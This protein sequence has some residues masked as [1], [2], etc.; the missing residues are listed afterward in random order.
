MQ[1]KRVDFVRFLAIIISFL[2]LWFVCGCSTKNLTQTEKVGSI[3]VESTISGAN[4]TLDNAATG[5]LTPD[6]LFDI[7]VGSH[8]IKVE[9]EG[10]IPSPTSIMVE[11][12]A[13]TIVQAS[14]VLLDL[15][16]GSL[17]VNSNVEGAYIAID[18]T[19]TDK[20][21]PFLFDH[22]LAVGT[23]IVSLFKDG[24]SNDAPAKEVVNI[25]TTDTV[26]LT[27]NLTSDSVGKK[28]GNITPD[29]NLE[30]DFGEWYRFYAYRGFVGIVNFWALSCRYCMEELP[31][32]QLLYTEYSS[33]SLK[34]FGINYEDDFD[35]IQQKRNE[36]RLTFI[37]LKG[38]DTTVK[39]DF[40]VTGTPVT[41]I[42]DRSG[43]IYYY[44]LGFSDKPDEIQN[45]MNTFR[46]KLNEVFGK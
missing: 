42:I 24:Y 2:V 36:L 7:K 8:L 23:H 20:Q 13:D 40:E 46:Q 39:S 34:I 12:K 29:F 28:V 37:L 41:I 21:T 38:S 16:Y 32:L 44:R 10:Y 27:F 15:N 11:V 18:N 31:Y 45:I 3:F 5:K 25:T 33:D 22:N 9:K 26:R 1:N 19:P 17:G 30:D 6:T 35:I 14:F 4:I 43:K